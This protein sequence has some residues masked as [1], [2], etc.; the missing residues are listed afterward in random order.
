[1]ARK[2]SLSPSEITEFL[3]ARNIVIEEGSNTKIDDD[4]V[5]LIIQQFAPDMQNAIDAKG[6]VQEELKAASHSI[7]IESDNLPENAPEPEDPESAAVVTAEKPEVIKA[8]KVE[9]SGLKVL[10]KIELPDLKKKVPETSAEEG[11]VEE[12][13]K[14]EPSKKEITERKS[15]SPRKEFR[16]PKTLKNPIAFEREREAQEA[17]EKRE[18][19]AERQKEIRTQNYL[20]KVKTAQ[21]TKA[22]KIVKEETEQMSAAELE[23]PPK[24]WWGKFAKWLTT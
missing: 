10:G 8:P 23:E 14:E 18:A 21:P 9:L 11:V 5:S 24:T 22:T 6:S 1:M 15:I 4:Y 7:P 2:L 13:S 19:E 12:P 20:K 17:K 16:R 3:A